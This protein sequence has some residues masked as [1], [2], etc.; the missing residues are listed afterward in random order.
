MC[1]SGRVGREYRAWCVWTNSR[2]RCSQRW[3]EYMDCRTVVSR[4]TDIILE[5]KHSRC[6]EAM[7]SW[8]EKT[9][10][11]GMVRL[12]YLEEMQVVLPLDI[13]PPI[14]RSDAESNTCAH[15]GWRPE[16]SSAHTSSR[17]RYTAAVVVRIPDYSDPIAVVV[18]QRGNTTSVDTLLR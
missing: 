15:V 1:R 4:T 13:F 14:V 18:F 2:E 10:L 7:V 16:A 12:E 17:A 8:S 5:K 9:N 3:D 11:P 6:Q